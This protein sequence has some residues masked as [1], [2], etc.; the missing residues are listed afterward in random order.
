MAL[1]AGDGEFYG[2]LEACIHERGLHPSVRM[3]GSVAAGRMPSLMAAADIFFLPSQWEGI[4][5]SI[6]EAMAAGLC[7][8][9]ADVGGQAEL[10]TPE[11]GVLLRFPVR[12]GEIEAAA[13]ARVLAGLL[14]EPERIAAYGRAARQRMRAHFELDSMG[15]RM[16]GHFER[17]HALR[18]EKPRQTISEPF[19]RELALQGI[20]MMRIQELADELWPLR[21]KHLDSL[22]G[23]GGPPMNLAGTQAHA[24]ANAE[25]TATLALI[26]SSRP[27]RAIQAMKGTG[28]YRMLARA[29]FGADWEEV[30]AKEPPEARLARIQGSRAYRIA[31]MLSHVGE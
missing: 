21:Q 16:L 1:V 17:A 5:L 8:V 6:Y 10:V 2:A 30:D 18:H 12:G 28:P 19:A 29:R 25:A 13:Y 26:E 23:T 24:A 15:A 9:G 11:T 14:A 3:L 7:V 22:R 27:W 4:A 20:E 31:R